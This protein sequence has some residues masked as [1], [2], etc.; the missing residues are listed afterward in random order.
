MVRNWPFAT[1]SPVKSARITIKSQ[2]SWLRRNLPNEVNRDLGIDRLQKRILRGVCG[3]HVSSQTPL[4]HHQ[5]AMAVIK[6]LGDFVGYKEHCDA[7][8]GQSPNDF[9]NPVLGADIDTDRR[10]VKN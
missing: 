9:I 3:Q 2:N 7:V 1:P 6:H 8:A 4:A 5:H 10:A